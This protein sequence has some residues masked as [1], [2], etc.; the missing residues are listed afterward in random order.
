MKRWITLSL[1]GL[2]IIAASVLAQ[3]PNEERLVCGYY[4]GENGAAAARERLRK[5]ES[6]FRQGIRAFTLLSKDP[7]GRARIAASRSGTVSETRIVSAVADLVSASG[8]ADHTGGE[9]DDR[10]YLTGADVGLS[11]AAVNSLTGSLA[12]GQSILITVVDDRWA[13]ETAQ[14]F[15]AEPG[16]INTVSLPL[17]PTA[18]R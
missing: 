16:L 11:P 10:Q 13:A 2:S 1:A 7:N 14:R 12:P 3:V 17:A 15:A 9:I 5:S 6:A 18:T 4:A 8:G